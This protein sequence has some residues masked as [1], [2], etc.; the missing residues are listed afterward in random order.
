[1]NK[2]TRHRL[3]RISIRVEIDYFVKVKAYTRRR[4][5]RIEKHGFFLCQMTL[6]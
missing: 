6:Y 1:M 2:R 3:A 4:Y 5:G